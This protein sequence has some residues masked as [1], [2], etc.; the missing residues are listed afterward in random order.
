MIASKLYQTQLWIVFLDTLHTTG[1]TFGL[2]FQVVLPIEVHTTEAVLLP[3][4]VEHKGQM[5]IMNGLPM[6]GKIEVDH[7]PE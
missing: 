5:A 7:N 2:G 1:P 6:V 3:F 4:V